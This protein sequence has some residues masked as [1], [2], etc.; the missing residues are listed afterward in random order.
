MNLHQ[1]FKIGRHMGQ[2]DQSDI[3]FA[4]AQGTMLL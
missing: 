1:F 4:I 2:D 3:C